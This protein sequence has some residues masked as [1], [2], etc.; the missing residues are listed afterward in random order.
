MRN[1][2]M[3]KCNVGFYQHI[4]ISNRWSRDY[5]D[6]RENKGHNLST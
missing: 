1:C 2:N 3:G 5:Y 4:H 6:S